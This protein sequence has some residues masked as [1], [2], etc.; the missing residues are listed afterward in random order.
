MRYQQDLHEEYLGEEPV[1]VT[2]VESQ[3]KPKKSKREYF[4]CLVREYNEMLMISENIKELK[5]D[6]K[7]AGFDSALLAKVAKAH[8]EAKLG[9]L[10]EKAQDLIDMIEAVENDTLPS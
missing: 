2:V 6:A 4:E 3:E 5:D 8:V 10:S 1:A 9:D 7:E